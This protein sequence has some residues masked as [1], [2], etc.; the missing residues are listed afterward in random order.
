MDVS[1]KFVLVAKKTNTETVKTWEPYDTVV[2]FKKKILLI[3]VK[4]DVL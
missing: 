3:W 2:F 4:M 1:T